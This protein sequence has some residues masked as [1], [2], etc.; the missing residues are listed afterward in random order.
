M[1]RLARARAEA[2]LFSPGAVEALFD[3]IGLPRP[4]KTSN[5]LASLEKKKLLTRVKKGHAG[6]AW[7]LTPEGKGQAEDL[8]TDC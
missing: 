5:I 8:A 6:V 3:D 1:A 4:A 2:G 7:K